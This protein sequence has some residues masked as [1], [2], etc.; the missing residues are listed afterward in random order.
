MKVS[1]G[2]IQI[3]S[4][5]AALGSGLPFGLAEDLGAAVRLLCRSG[6]PAVSTLPQALTACTSN[7]SHRPPQITIK[8]STWYW[9]ATLPSKALY[10]TVIG[11]SLADSLNAVG[12]DMPN[13]I[14]IND[15]DAPF[16]LPGF[17]AHSSV[18]C[19]VRWDAAS[20]LVA[21]GMVSR[22]DPGGAQSLAPNELSD[23]V[24]EP[25]NDIDTEASLSAVCNWDAAP[26][27]GVEVDDDAWRRLEELAS[28]ILVPANEMSRLRGAGAGL[29]DTD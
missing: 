26:R 7:D 28:A 16:L 29:I 20:V 13:R 24:I 21:N 12:S 15:V 19:R 8:E 9:T 6:L 14:V 4:R 17:L 18:R 22:I 25:L 5:K 27:T 3:L 11:P 1:L 2:E 23:V 10:S